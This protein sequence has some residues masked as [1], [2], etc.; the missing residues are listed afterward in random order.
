MTAPVAVTG[1]G[2][3]TPAG[4]D[5]DATWDAVCRGAGSA[6]AHDPELAGLPVD[7]SCRVPLSR[8]A[9]DRRVGRAAWRMSRNA[10]L[11]VL[12]A[13][14]AV[15]DAGLDPRTWNGDRVAVV[16]GHSL[17]AAGDVG[18]ALTVLTVQHGT[19]PPVANLDA[20]APGFDIDCVT[21]EPR[22]QDVRVAV[23]HSFDFGGHNVVLA[24]AGSS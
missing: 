17:G 9:L 16:V 24:L 2:L 18:A 13:R 6:A 22:R 11:A 1:V 5:A 19:V 4:Q 23:S 15:R 7:F 20:P 21:D 3:L 12:A 8:E 10:V 14:E